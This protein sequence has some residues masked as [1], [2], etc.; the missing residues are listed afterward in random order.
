MVEENVE[1]LDAEGLLSPEK[2]NQLQV[3]WRRFTRHRLT[4][5]GLVVISVFILMAI[6]ANAL[7]PY[8]PIEDQDP[9]LKN[10]QPS[11]DHLLGTDEIGRDVFSRLLF[12]ARILLS[13][14]W[15]GYRVILGVSSII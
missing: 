3:V 12:A 8:H 13:V 2:E 4:L 10:A 5:A 9:Y 6:F 15:A 7:A 14:A 1:R 11:A